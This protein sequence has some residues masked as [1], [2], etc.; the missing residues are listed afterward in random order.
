MWHKKNDCENT[1]VCICEC[2]L[3]VR[4]SIYLWTGERAFLW[5]FQIMRLTWPHTHMSL[6]HCILFVSV[7][8]T[9]SIRIAHTYKAY[10]PHPA[11]P[12]TPISLP[13]ALALRL[14]GKLESMTAYNI[15]MMEMSLTEVL[16]LNC[17]G[18]SHLH[19]KWLSVRCWRKHV[20][21]F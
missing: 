14:M 20:C 15:T 2:I 16:W 17:M 12:P 6:C 10:G 5:H 18:G 1:N 9:T 4:M 3:R 8:Q 7:N 21:Y 13:D 11:A 19:Y